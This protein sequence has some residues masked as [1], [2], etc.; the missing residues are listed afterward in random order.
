MEQYG[1]SVAGNPFDRLQFDQGQLPWGCHLSRDAIRAAAQ[2]CKDQLP[3]GSDP[4]AATRL[5]CAA[6]SILEAA[7]W[8]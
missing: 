8:K 6:V 1:F 2:H 7:G 4:A 5:D 3:A